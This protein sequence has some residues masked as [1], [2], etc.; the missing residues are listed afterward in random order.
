MSNEIE[1]RS[2]TG[3]VKS[4]ARTLTA[5]PRGTTRQRKLAAGKTL[6]WK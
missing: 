2:S 5:T 4:E 1:R 3:E 6:L